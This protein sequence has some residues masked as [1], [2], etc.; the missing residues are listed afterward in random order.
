M[1]RKM[2]LLQPTLDDA[3]LASADLVIEAVVEK[4]G[5]KQTVFAEL[6]AAPVADDAILASNTSSLSIDAIGAQTPAPRARGRH[7]LLQPGGQDAAGRGDRRPRTRRRRRCDTVAAFA[8]QLGKTPVL[9]K[10]GPGFLVNRLLAFYSAEALWLLDEGHRIEDIDRAM[11]DWG[12][13]MGPMALTDEVGIDV[14]DE[15]RATSCTTPS[16]TACRS[17]PGSTARRDSGP[18]GDQ[19]RQAGFYR[20]EGRERTDAGPRG[21]RAILGRRTAAREPPTRRVSPSAWCCRWST[22][23]PAASTR[24]SSRGRRPS[25]TWR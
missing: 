20:Y 10:D 23:P 12:M 15:G 7:A 14:A 4:L 13:P 1:R 2:A 25:S 11:V 18:A 19:E 24:G 22:R 5:V 6:G 8:R 17:R 16:A 9:V 3:G 21:L